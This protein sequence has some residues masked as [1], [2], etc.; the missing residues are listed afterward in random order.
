MPDWLTE[1]KEESGT[2]R[3]CCWGCGAIETWLGRF[4]EPRSYMDRFRAHAACKAIYA[5]DPARFAPVFGP[6]DRLL[7][8]VQKVDVQRSRRTRWL[9]GECLGLSSDRLNLYRVRVDG[10]REITECPLGFLKLNIR[11]TSPTASEGDAHVH[12]AE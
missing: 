1:A 7:V 10:D 3:R 9:P 6:G 11:N 8:Q 12:C 5:I 4:N 2:R